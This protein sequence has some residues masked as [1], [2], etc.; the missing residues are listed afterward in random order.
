[1][2]G[3]IYSKGKIHQIEEGS[4][5]QIN[6]IVIKIISEKISK[7]L[8]GYGAA[9]IGEKLISEIL[10]NDIMEILKE[11]ENFCAKEISNRLIS[12]FN[13]KSSINDS[14]ALHA[15]QS[16][17]IKELKNIFNEKAERFNEKSK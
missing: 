1:M 15:K 9:N 4:G 13:L 5:R 6:E 10:K 3:E 16:D 2:N 12:E 17:I 7:I 11:H 14:H 8:F